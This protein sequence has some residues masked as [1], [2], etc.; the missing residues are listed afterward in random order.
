MQ[1]LLMKNY[2]F[3]VLLFV[4]AAIHAQ[5]ADSLKR[6]LPFAKS[7]TARINLYVQIAEA[8]EDST[9]LLYS[10]TVQRLINAQLSKADGNLKTALYDYLSDAIYNKG[11]Y[12]ANTEQYDTAIYFLNAAM[13]PALTSKNRKKEAQ[14]LNDLGIC[15]YYENNVIAAVDY[16]RKSLAIREELNEETELI[17]AYN[18]TAFI[19]REIGL[20]ENSLELHFKSMALAEK[21]KSDDDIARSLNNIGAIYHQVLLDYPKGLEYYKKSLVIREKL[22]DKK[23]IAL[24]KNNIASLY[25]DMKNYTEAIQYYNESLVLRREVNHKYGIVQTLGNLAF[26]YIEM[27]DFE[28][29]KQALIESDELNKTLRDQNLQEAIHYK[30]AMLYDTLHLPDSAIYH[31]L[32][33]HNICLELGN[34]L[35]ISKSA[36]LVS[37]LYEK[38]ND[39]NKSL[40]FYKLYK[41]MQD[42]ILNSNL[43]KQGVKSELEY[44]YLK[45][46]T[47]SDKIYNDQ[48]A[49]KNFYTSLLVVLFIASA[50]IAFVLYK[51]YKLK[52]QLKEVEIRNKIASDLHDDVGSTLSSIRMYSDIVNNQVKESNPQSTILLNK[53]SSNSKEMIENMSDIV[54]M[55]KPGN[56]EFKNIENRM[57][58]FA[59]ELC[60]PAGINFEFNKDEAT[61]AI[62]ISMEQRRD[63]YLIF[64]EA[65]NNAVKYSGCHSIRAVLTLQ[66]QKLQMRISDDGNGFDTTAAKNG[67]GLSNMQKRAEAH[68]GNFTIQ[69]APDD[70]TEMIVSFSV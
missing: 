36:L 3:I 6:L 41:K 26:N 47:E 15:A 9:A 16:T 29:A 43:K 42:S 31:A 67:N 39:Y 57:L 62:Q 48:L 46:K 18:N 25:G 55:I 50:I 8:G 60:T 34:P 23:A 12:F 20:I 11:I 53:I 28:K 37:E 49:R 51:R 24:I 13:Q 68:K 56:D 21:E 35:D 33:S 44:E 7:D 58:N 64:K 61:D 40:T 30:Y 54:W 38:Q 10:D 22:G 70:G 14:I 4:T 69:S 32:K 52:Q 2:V 45:K 1:F 17:E 5:V 63:I 27:K 19:Y 66:K 59:N 65:V